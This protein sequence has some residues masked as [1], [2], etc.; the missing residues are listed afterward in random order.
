M[1]SGI[2]IAQAIALP[3]LSWPPLWAVLILATSML[4][5]QSDP[6]NAASKV[7]VVVPVKHSPSADP[8]PA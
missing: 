7:A 1:L 5:S 8:E 3:D 4:A 6:S 2:L